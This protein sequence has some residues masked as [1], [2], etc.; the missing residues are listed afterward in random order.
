MNTND[1]N[2]SDRRLL[3]S[4]QSKIRFMKR[5]IQICEKNHL[6]DRQTIDIGSELGAKLFFTK[7]FVEGFTDGE[8]TDVKFSMNVSFGIYESNYLSLLRQ[9]K[10][11]N[12]EPVSELSD[13][14]DYDEIS[15]RMFTSQRMN[16]SCHP[17]EMD[18]KIHYFKRIRSTPSEEKSLRLDLLTLEDFQDRFERN[19]DTTIYSCTT[20]LALMKKDYDALLYRMIIVKFNEGIGVY[21]NEKAIVQPGDAASQMLERGPMSLYQKLI[22]VQIVQREPNFTLFKYKRI[23]SSIFLVASIV[24]ILLFS[25][26]IQKMDFK[27][28]GLLKILLICTLFCLVLYNLMYSFEVS[29]NWLTN[30]IDSVINAMMYSLIL[31]LNL[32]LIDSQTRKI[33]TNLLIVGES[34]WETLKGR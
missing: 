29:D 30:F 12:F 15:T 32:I 13:I 34:F 8:S 5:H 21:N 14:D 7:E 33:R 25:L 27:T 24:N 23:M 11:Y 17:A 6:G 19:M 16:F 3:Q 22:N 26:K 28:M 9:C 20:D 2:D 4:A 10:K 18:D 1:T 31:F